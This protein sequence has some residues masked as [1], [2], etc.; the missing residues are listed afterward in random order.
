M[1]YF[2]KH[3][4]RHFGKHFGPGASDKQTIRPAVVA[5]LRADARLASAISG[6]V[7]PMAVPL[8]R[9]MPSLAYQLLS[10]QPQHDLDGP[11]GTRRAR[12]KFSVVGQPE[13]MES[14]VDIVEVIRDLFDGYSGVLEGIMIDEAMQIDG[15]DTGEL[16]PTQGDTMLSVISVDYLFLYQG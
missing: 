15:Q 12:F 13:H 11:D 4:G 9:P 5:A 16:D 3:F 8:N 14:Q 7:Y 10:D 1:A 2:G 6:R